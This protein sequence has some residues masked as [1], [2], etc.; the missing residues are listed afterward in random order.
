MCLQN[1]P[2][3]KALHYQYRRE[4]E[5]TFIIH[6]AAAR[7]LKSHVGDSGKLPNPA[8]LQAEYNKL[9]DRKNAL[10]SEYGKL[11]Q[12]AQEYGIVKK[13]VD[14]ILNPA[15]ERTHNRDRSTEL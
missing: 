15:T 9:T 5:S 14:S 8:A 12:Q 7:A 6:E 2:K 1:Q 4:H 3:S 13:N 11:K 10:R